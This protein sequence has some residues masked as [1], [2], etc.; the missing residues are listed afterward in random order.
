MA[1]GNQSKVSSNVSDFENDD[2]KSIE[3][4]FVD[5]R[6]KPEGKHPILKSS[7]QSMEDFTSKIF[8]ITQYKSIL[9]YFY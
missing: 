2:D 1:G 4:N 6:E 7:K 9:T 3:S 5:A 8:T